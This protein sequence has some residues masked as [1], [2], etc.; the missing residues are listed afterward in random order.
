MLDHAGLKQLLRARAELSAAMFL[1]CKRLKQERARERDQEVAQVPSDVAPIDT[2][3][4][5]V[6]AASAGK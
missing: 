3:R 1:A 4:V 5:K 2:A 6:R